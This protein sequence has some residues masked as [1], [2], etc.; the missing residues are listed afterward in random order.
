M[1]R[2]CGRAA[3]SVTPPENRR[4][5]SELKALTPSVGGGKIQGLHGGLEGGCG[6]LVLVGIGV[7]LD[8]AGQDAGRRGL[9]LHGG[10]GNALLDR[11]TLDDQSAGRRRGVLHNFF[12]VVRVLGVIGIFC[13]GGLAQLGLFALETGEFNFEVRAGGVLPCGTEGGL[14]DGL[15]A[16]ELL[17]ERDACPDELQV[18]ELAELRAQRSRSFL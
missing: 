6:L 11:S 3:H 8:L 10:D 16:Q 4:R 13:L 2:T 17:D 14:V 1:W 9:V 15:V 12:S 7:F 18:V 5:Y